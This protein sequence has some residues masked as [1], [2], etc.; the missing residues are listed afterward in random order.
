[1]RSLKFWIKVTRPTQCLIAGLATYVIALLSNGHDWLT[2]SKIASSLSM[3]ICVLGASLFHYGA[4]NKMYAR[5][6]WDLVEVT[7][8]WILIILGSMAFLVSSLIAYC[9]L[10][11]ICVCIT[12]VN[13]LGIGF[14]SRVLSRHWSTKNPFI[15]FICSTPVLIGWLSGNNMHPSLPYFFAIVFFSYLGRE[16]FKDINDIEVNG[17]IRVTLPIWL[18]SIKHALWI[19]YTSI[20]C[21][22]IFMLFLFNI[23]KTASIYA[24]TFYLIALITFCLIPFVYLKKGIRSLPHVITIA[25]SLIIMS[26]LALKTSS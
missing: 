17:G 6:N 9:Y 25:N 8:P 12:I 5:K 26:I 24:E 16:I 7:K 13:S 3:S 23:Y 19:A 4:A 14:Y 10:P 2:A 11:K 20:V 15:A 18:G 21:S 1:M 22:C